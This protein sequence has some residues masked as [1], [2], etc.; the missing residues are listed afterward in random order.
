[1]NIIQAY[2][3]LSLQD[4]EG[5]IWKDI[6]DYEELYQISNHGRV[7][8]LARMKSNGFGY[9]LTKERILK[10]TFDKK[11]GVCRVS[12]K[13]NNLQKGC[14]IASTVLHHF[15]KLPV[16]QVYHIDG[17][18]TNNHITNL[19]HYTSDKVS[20]R[21]TKFQNK[22]GYSFDREKKVYITRIRVNKK[23]YHI[24]SF[25]NEIEAAKAYDDFVIKHHLRRKGNF[26]D[27]R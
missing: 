2:L 19:Q 11:G 8:S 4:R 16:V 13:N 17:D 23:L 22:I 6:C 15:N 10:Q 3:D 21:R 20:C 5:E 7:K 14:T 1:M 27:N 18:L 12:F 25:V 24:G 9:H 26:I